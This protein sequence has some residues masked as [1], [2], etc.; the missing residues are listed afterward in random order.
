[1]NATLLSKEFWRE[2]K[3]DFTRPDFRWHIFICNTSPAFED[4]YKWYYDDVVELARQFLNET[5]W[6]ESA[7]IYSDR[8]VLFDVKQGYDVSL[9][10]VRLDFI[11]W[12]LA[13]LEAVEI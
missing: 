4:A 8:N 12:N 10:L 11:N 2:V 13:K 1:M 3:A 7:Y 5:S 6:G 9:R